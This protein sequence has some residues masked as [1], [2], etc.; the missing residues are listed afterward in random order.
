MKLVTLKFKIIIGIILFIVLVGGAYSSTIF[1]SGNKSSAQKIGNVVYNGTFLTPVENFTT[2]TSKY[3]ARIDPISK[4]ESYHTGIDLVGNTGSNIL[5]VKDGEVTWAGWSDT[6]YGNCVE[7]KHIDETGKVF[8]S[9]YAHMRDNSI[10]V[11]TGEMVVEGQVL[12]IQGSSG[13]STGEHLHFEIRLEDKSKID[14]T[15]YLFNAI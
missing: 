10:C 11:E 15:P 12:G 14:P 2:V 5:N 13:W 1:Y 3:G 9:F 4:E 7:I 6:G 8:Y